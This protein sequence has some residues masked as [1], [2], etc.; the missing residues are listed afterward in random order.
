VP[1][2]VLVATEHNVAPDLQVQT[3][4]LSPRGRLRNRPSR[5]S[6]RSEWSTTG[7][8]RGRARGYAL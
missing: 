2:I 8:D 5:Q 4:A 3:A 7:R 1:L 6:L